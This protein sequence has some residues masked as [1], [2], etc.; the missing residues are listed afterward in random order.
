[1]FPYNLF[2]VTHVQSKTSR[3]LI[4]RFAEQ[5][6][7]KTVIFVAALEGHAIVLHKGPNASAWIVIDSNDPFGDLRTGRG[8]YSDKYKWLTKELVDTATCQ[9]HN[10][11]GVHLT[12]V[13]LES[14]LSTRLSV[15]TWGA[16]LLCVLATTCFIALIR[17]VMEGEFCD[18]WEQLLLHC[19][20]AAGESSSIRF[21]LSTLQLMRTLVESRYSLVLLCRTN[22]PM[23][24]QDNQDSNLLLSILKNRA[25][26][27]KQEKGWLTKA[28]KCSPNDDHRLV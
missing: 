5:N 16:C 18:T 17:P 6:K 26:Q 13:S 22:K 3:D 25:R 27:H 4:T 23:T 8:A 24:N 10:V 1:M 19:R 21:V 2:F 14:A 11:P 12:Q 28:S 20:T 7:S 9:L 15:H